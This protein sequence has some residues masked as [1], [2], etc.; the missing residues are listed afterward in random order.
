MIKKVLPVV[1]GALGGY[2]Y[3]HF[4]GCTQGSCPIQGNPYLSTGYG[5]LL[6]SIFIMP[7]K[8]KA[9]SAESER[10]K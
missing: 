7:E 2:L 1:L 6:G 10:G 4:I 8:K 9:A 3:Y 5:A